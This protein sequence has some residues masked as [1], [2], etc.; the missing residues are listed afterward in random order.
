MLSRLFIAAF[1]SPAGKGLASWLLSVTFNFVFVTFPCG[2]LDQ[3]WY[4]IVSILDLCHLS[5]FG[6]F[7]ILRGSGPVLLRNLF[8]GG[9]WIP[10]PRPPP[11]SGSTHDK[12]DHHV[13]SECHNLLAVLLRIYSS[14]GLEIRQNLSLQN[15][16]T[17][18]F[19]QRNQR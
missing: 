8:S 11:P 12:F 9:V 5:Y 13:C 2:T 18:T 7:V 19:S 16:C 15:M 3:V 1:W 17:L 6:S 14:R 4:L 10:C